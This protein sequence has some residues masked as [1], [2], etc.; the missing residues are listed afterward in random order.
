[1]KSYP[2]DTAVAMA[3]PRA[4]DFPLPLAAVIHTVLRKVFSDIASTNFK[5]A[6]A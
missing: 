5:R 3:I 6:F 1:M 4:A 2:N